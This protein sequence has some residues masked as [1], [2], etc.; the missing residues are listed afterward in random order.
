MKLN[1][2]IWMLLAGVSM[3]ASCEIDTAPEGA[4]VTEQQ[5]QEI[6]D[7]NPDRIAADVVNLAATVFM[8][9]TVGGTN[10]YA[11]DFGLPSVSIAN[12]YNGADMVCANND[13][14]WYMPACD[15]TDRDPNYIVP[16]VEWT[17]Y[18]NYLKAANDILA[19]IPAETENETLKAYRGQALGA[20]AL[21]IFNLVQR[22]Q[23]TY[24]GNEDK[25]TVPIV[26]D[27][28][29]AEQAS[30]NPRATL[31]VAYEQILGDLNEA[32]TLL[33]GYTRPNKSTIDQQVAYG[34]RARVN[35]VMQNY[36]E[37]ASD[38]ANALAG[39]T[40]YSIAELGR[41]TFQDG[42]HHAW[43]WGAIINE[44]DLVSGSKM[45]T[46]QS[47]VGSLNEGYCAKCSTYA[48]C[49]VE[50]Y[51][52]IPATDVRK[53]W[54][55]D[56]NLKSPLIEGLEWPGAPGVSI[57]EAEIS[58]I[59]TKFYPYT[60]VKFG[61]TDDKIG[62]TDNSGDWPL[63]RAEEMY[64]IQA[65]ATGL[66]GNITEGAKLLENFMKTYRDPDYKCTATDEDTF[67][68]E[69]WLQRRIELWGE[70]FFF[71]DM[72]R[73]NKPLVR[74][75]GSR[76]DQTNWP[77]AYRF[78]I[79]AGDEV[80]LCA[81]PRSEINSNEGISEEENNTGGTTPVPDQNPNL[82]DGVTD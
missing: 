72:M 58:Q 67:R 42:T 41:P 70:G 10:Y 38:A 5:K 24:K 80:F 62:N 25:P 79:P 39:Y 54:W 7:M 69:I 63:M 8:Q 28:M 1:N 3:L 66:G 43:I 52:K 73:F 49:N 33:E 78:N 30:N 50:L 53:G 26:T 68:N 22:F 51:N 40:P 46:W 81:I 44:S 56:E 47:W 14:N 64:L 57:G 27:G 17:F 74:F 71:T 9:F 20:R 21:A 15:Y 2:K 32:I 76:K 11:I 18:Y 65:E 37:A 6:V 60:N 55:V 45:M 4:T 13:Y 29:S 36:A 23:F 31:S 59:K 35:L 34:L 48:R 77:D 16:Y 82:L 19:A 61:P 75:H 12:D